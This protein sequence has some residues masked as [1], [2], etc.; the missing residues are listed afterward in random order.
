VAFGRQRGRRVKAD[1]FAS[2]ALKLA[3]VGEENQGSTLL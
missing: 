1:R 2:K 3:G